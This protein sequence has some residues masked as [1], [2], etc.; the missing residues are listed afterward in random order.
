MAMSKP[1]VFGAAC[2]SGRAEG[3]LRL[4]KLIDQCCLQAA[5]ARQ[6]KHV[7]D[8]VCLA[9]SHQL[10]VGEAAVGAENDARTAIFGGSAR[11]C[12]RSPRPRHHSPRRSHAAGQQQPRGGRPQP[13]WREPGRSLP[14][15][16]ARR[17]GAAMTGVALRSAGRP[18][19][20]HRPKINLKRAR[21]LGPPLAANATL[22]LKTGACVRRARLVMV[23]PGPRHPRRSQAEIPLID[24]SEVGQP[25]LSRPERLMM[26]SL[27]QTLP[28]SQQAGRAARG[29]PA[30]G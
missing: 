6:A 12:A 15:G 5:I 20:A 29:E 1:G 19:R 3:A 7:V 30:D 25:T 27:F 9:P 23:A 2:G 22:A 26:T 18:C 24:L 10:V 16:I 21:Y 4:G 13:T 8:A 14:Q 11:Q 28:E 17:A